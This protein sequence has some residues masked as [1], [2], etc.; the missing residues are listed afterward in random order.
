MRKTNE[1]KIRSCTL[2][3]SESLY[4]RELCNKNCKNV[5]NKKVKYI[6]LLQSVNMAEEV[7][8][9]LLKWKQHIRMIQECGSATKISIHAQYKMAEEHYKTQK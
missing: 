2:V 5:I 8:K 7:K 9:Y 1:S 6:D 4:E 3:I